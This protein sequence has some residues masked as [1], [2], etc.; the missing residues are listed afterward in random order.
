MRLLGRSAAALKKPEEDQAPPNH[1]M[2]PIAGRLGCGLVGSHPDSLPPGRLKIADLEVSHPARISVRHATTRGCALSLPADLVVGGL[3]PDS[4]AGQVAK[5]GVGVQGIVHVPD[6][7][8][9]ELLARVSLAHAASKVI[10][11]VL[12]SFG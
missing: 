2:G 12:C 9:E 5:I 4:N 1:G 10:T 3:F 7:G 11:P 8:G 6:L